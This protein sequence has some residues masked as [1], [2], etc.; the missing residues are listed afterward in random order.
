M[1]VGQYQNVFGYF[2]RTTILLLDFPFNNFARCIS[3]YQSFSLSLF[4]VSI[5]PTVQYVKNVEFKNDVQCS[6]RTA[7]GIYIKSRQFLQRYVNIYYRSMHARRFCFL[8]VCDDTD[9][10]HNK[11]VI[12]CIQAYLEITLRYVLY[13]TL[14]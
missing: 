5:A 6:I 1:L 8:G 13:S 3:I 14:H 7:H 11:V 4:L 12:Y 9:T 10:A 2:W